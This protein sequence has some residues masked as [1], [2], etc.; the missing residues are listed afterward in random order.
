MLDA[1][2]Y[3]AVI[4]HH[5][6]YTD[7]SSSN[8][9]TPLLSPSSLGPSP[10]S[11]RCRRLP[12]LW[13]R[14]SASLSSLP[15]S[16]NLTHSLRSS[17]LIQLRRRHGRRSTLSSVRPA[18]VPSFAVTLLYFSSSRSFKPSRLSADCRAPAAPPLHSTITRSL[19]RG[20]PL[21]SVRSPS[22]RLPRHS[23]IAPG[24]PSA[25]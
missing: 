21:R 7:S 18:L 1:Q 8:S 17:L 16:P 20:P 22:P 13:V 3:S 6:S 4:C 14:E 19:H 24:I 2:K 9:S 25:K 23:A 15:N 5:N 11:S 10:P 12:T